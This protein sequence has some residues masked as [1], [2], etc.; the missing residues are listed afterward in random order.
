[1]SWFQTW[2]LVHKSPCVSSAGFLLAQKS[3]EKSR[4]PS[5]TAI[6]RSGVFPECLTIG[7]M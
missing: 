2:L 6:F 3:R 1:M 4:P 5:L 7:L